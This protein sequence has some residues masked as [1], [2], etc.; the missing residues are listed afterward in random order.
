MENEPESI[1]R[2]ELQNKQLDEELDLWWQHEVEICYIG[3][4]SALKKYNDTKNDKM[5]LDEIKKWFDVM[6][7]QNTNKRLHKLGPKKS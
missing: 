3:F 1:E 4:Q 6:P 5:F 2:A 7:N